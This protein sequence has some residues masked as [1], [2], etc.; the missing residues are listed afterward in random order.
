MRILAVLAAMIVP[1]AF[2]LPVYQEREKAV[3]RADEEI[4]KLETR[5]EQAQAAQRKLTQF[6]EEVQRLN[7]EIVKLR[8]ILPPDPAVDQIRNSVGAAAHDSGVHIERFQPK[9][10]VKREYIEVPIDT[11]AIGNLSQLE[12]FFERLANNSRVMNVTEVTLTPVPPGQWRSKF[13]VT[14]FALP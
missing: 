5:I 12:T 6:H 13:V 4:R 7:T 1:L 8:N 9:D 11:T 10:T 14:A 2:Y 3:A